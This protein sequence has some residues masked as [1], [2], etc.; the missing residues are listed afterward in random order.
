MKSRVFFIYA[1][2]AYA[3]G[4]ASIAYIA[5]FLAD[6]AVPKGISDGDP[7]SLWAAVLVDAVLVGLFGLHH[8]LAA[9]SSFKRRWTKLVPPA[10]ERATFLYMTAAMTAVLVVFWRPIPLVIWD[11]QAPLAAGLMYTAYLATWAMMTAATFHF[12]HFGFFG[13]AQAWA[14]L[15]RSPPAPGRLSARYLYALVRHPISLGWMLTPWLTPQLTLGHVVFGV[16]AFLYVMAATPFE[17][18]DLVAE[19]GEGYRDY[20]RRGPA[21]LPGLRPRRRRDAAAAA[22]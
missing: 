11:L 12:G 4:T 3:A 10:I 14:Y 15:R 1:L 2:G 7:T 18:A 22:E 9:R 13:L 16:S 20:R 5:G 19:L 6:V 21:F 8:S 17:E